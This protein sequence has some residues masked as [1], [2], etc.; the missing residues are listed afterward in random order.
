M[1]QVIDP[2]VIGG[3]VALAIF[4]GV[5]LFLRLGRR[6]GLWAIAR[7]GVAGTPNISSLEAAVFALLGLLI[8]FTFSGALSRFDIRRA[9]AV[10]EANAIGT[11]YLRIDLLPAPA[12]PA[13]REAFRSYVDARIAT[14]RKLPDID[15]ATR[16]FLR[17]QQVRSE[18]L[19]QAVA[20]IRVQVSG[21]ESEFVLLA[22]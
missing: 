21:P 18:I 17:W 20:G 7:D 3:T 4:V 22:G 12:Q 2:I 8:A 11:A 16:E 14:Y 1:L 9:Q 6:V 19:V 13:L 10:D 5:V 15:A